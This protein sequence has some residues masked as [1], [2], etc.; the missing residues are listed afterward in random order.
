MRRRLEK[1]NLGFS[2]WF[3]CQFKQHFVQYIIHIEYF[4]HTNR[5]NIWFKIAEKCNAKYIGNFP[6]N[7]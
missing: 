7:M 4:L 6:Y 5:T 2:T 1:N 3:F